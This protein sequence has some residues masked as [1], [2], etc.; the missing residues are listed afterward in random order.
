MSSNAPPVS[1]TVG[2]SRFYLWVILMLLLTAL[3]FAVTWLFQSSGAG[4]SA[5]LMVG[6]L[7]FMVGVLL[8]D[9]RSSPTGILQWDGRSWLWTAA[10]DHPVSQVSVQLD[11]QDVLL[12]T[13][14]MA[15]GRRLWLWVQHSA[16]PARWLALRRALMA[17]GRQ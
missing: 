11:L 17:H 12:L 8:W 2:R 10:G 7:P 14:E 3:V 13:C 9:W 16:Q 15:T 4:W 6:W 5:R 1:Y